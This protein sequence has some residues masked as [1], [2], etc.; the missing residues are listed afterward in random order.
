MANLLKW[1]ESKL[2]GGAH[3]HKRV[4]TFQ[5]L[6][7]MGLVGAALMILNSFLRVETIDPEPNPAPAA[8]LEQEVF[9]QV[10]T[11]DNP[12][13]AY[14]R[15]YEDRL[16]EIL[17]KIV[18]V[19]NVDVMVTI[20]STEESIVYR[21]M[22]ETEQ[23]TNERDGNGAQRHITSVTRDGTIA[24]YTVSGQSKPIILKLIKPHIRGVI[25]VAGGAENSVVKQ[26]LSEAVQRGLGVA[27]TRVSILPRKT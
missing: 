8:G 1:L 2:G 11:T 3:G 5:W 24:L 20:E 4:R 26:M 18:G 14:E 16:R 25:I 19:G 13:A 15:I 27:P 7:L 10:E 22:H 21:D 12:F 17:E 9:R 6:V 23:E